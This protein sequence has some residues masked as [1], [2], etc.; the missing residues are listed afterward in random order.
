MSEAQWLLKQLGPVM[1]RC[2]VLMANGDKRLKMALGI[3]NQDYQS[4]KEAAIHRSFDTEIYAIAAQKVL[5]S[6]NS[7]YAR[8]V[9]SEV[10]AE[11]R[12]LIKMTMVDNKGGL[13]REDN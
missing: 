4:A 10:A 2:Q 6:P 8:N 13:V 11:F 3:S 7:L 5:N 1:H 12:R 9:K